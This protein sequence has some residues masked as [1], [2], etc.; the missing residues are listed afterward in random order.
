MMSD[1]HLFVLPESQKQLWQELQEHFALLDD[2]SLYLAGGTALALQTGHRESVDFDFFTQEKNIREHIEEWLSHFPSGV[3]R[4]ADAHTVH[5]SVNS[6]NV[7]F[8]GA[9][10]YPLI[11]KAVP[12]GIIPCASILDIALMK[13]LSITHRAVLR[14]YI[15]LALIIRDHIPLQTIINRSAEKYGENFSAMLPIRALSAFDDIDDDMPI[16]HDKKLASDWKDIIREA[17]SKLVL[18][19]EN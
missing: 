4:E 2:P 10:K 16:L 18:K 7:S 13:L 3:V 8:I 9:Y 15:D 17:M 11:E 1:V 5:A 12:I 14:D 19:N 6:V